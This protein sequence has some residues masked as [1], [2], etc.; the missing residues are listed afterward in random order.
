MRQVLWLFTCLFPLILHSQSLDLTG[1]ISEWEGKSFRSVRKPDS[2]AG[3]NY[4][5]IKQRLDIEVDPSKYFIE[6]QVETTVR[7]TVATAELVF[8]CS[9]SLKVDSIWYKGSLWTNYEI[10]DDRLRIDLGELVSEGRELSLTIHYHG[11]PVAGRSFVADTTKTGKPVM[12][13]LSEPYGAKDW[14]PCKQDLLDKIDT[15]VFSITVP[16]QYTAVANGVQL[17]RQQLNLNRKKFTYRHNYPIVTYLVAFA[18]AD[19]AFFEEEVSLSNGKLPFI[20]YVYPEDSA[21]ARQDMRDFEKTIQLFDTLFTP[22]PFMD[23]HYGHAQFTWGGGMEHQT[24]SFMFHFRHSLVAHELAHQWFGNLITC[25]S[26]QDLWLNEGFAT[27][28]DGLTYD[29]L[30]NEDRWVGWKQDQMRVITESG[31]GSVFIPD[32]S[33]VARMFDQRLTYRKGAYLLHMLR[34]Q[35]GDKAFYNAIRSYLKDEKL[36]YGFAKTEDLIWHFKKLAPEDMDIDEFFEDWYYRQG[37]PIYNIE[38]YQDEKNMVY[39]VL[40]QDQSYVWEGTF[41]DMKIPIQL[42]TDQSDTTVWLP[43]SF[44]GQQYQV[45][46]EYPLRAFI[47]DPELWILRGEGSVTKVDYKHSTVSYKLAPNPANDV[48]RVYYSDPIVPGVEVEVYDI[49]GRLCLSKKVS[50]GL[51]SEYFDLPINDLQSGAYTMSIKDYFGKQS[52]RL[53]KN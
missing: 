23:E 34:G 12:W 38:Y 18:V 36:Y 43:H 7:V 31:V 3:S 11:I 37:W 22:Y 5:V 19:Y 2:K 4:N 30:F 24:M 44:D 13:T 35:M 47:F 45:Q 1:E 14:W 33:D 32:T 28:L 26:W 41:F 27:Y 25:G 48:V 10:G 9:D 17:G 8:D 50:L 6:G 21:Q 42:V 40:G 20:N 52:L 15:L 53:V 46:L 29:Y 49:Y 51:G 39:I 16:D